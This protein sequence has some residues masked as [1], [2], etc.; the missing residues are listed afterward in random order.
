MRLIPAAGGAVAAPALA[1]LAYPVCCQCHSIRGI[2]GPKVG[3]RYL[4]LAERGTGRN[5]AFVVGRRLQFG[6]QPDKASF[7]ELKNQ[8]GWGGFTTHDLH[9]CQLAAR[10]VALI[11]NWWSLFVRLANPPS[12]TRG[13]HQPPVVDVL[14]GAPD[15][16]RWPDNDHA[17]R[18][19]C[20][21][22]Q[23]AGCPDAC[24]KPC[25]RTGWLV[26]R[27]S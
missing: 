12:P 10:T 6:S 14:G 26:L 3:G 21:I 15:G 2:S 23:G 5:S 25:F 18:P 19:A 22:C 8:W 11:Y 9:C 13:D 17:D 4:L 24:L 20:R 7:D 27:S 16:T 1:T